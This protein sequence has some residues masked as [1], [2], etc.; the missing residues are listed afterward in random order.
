M[1]HNSL[2]TPLRVCLS[3]QMQSAL[4]GGV[5]MFPFPPLL[6]CLFF[7]FFFCFFVSLFSPPLGLACAFFSLVQLR[8]MT[9]PFFFFLP[10]LL[11]YKC[12]F[13]SLTP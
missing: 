8:N 13:L 10:L 4:G 9:F 2:P 12:F 1:N 11:P 5:C 3:I 6:A 7:S